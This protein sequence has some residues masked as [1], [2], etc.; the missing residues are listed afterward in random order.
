[1]CCSAFSES[2]ARAPGGSAD[3]GQ[4]GGLVSQ[5]SDRVGIRIGNLIVANEIEDVEALQCP[6]G[7]EAV[8]SVLLVIEELESD[9]QFGQQEK[10]QVLAL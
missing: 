10:L 4:I 6:I 8:H 1:M 3:L 5:G 7:E 2:D 9:G